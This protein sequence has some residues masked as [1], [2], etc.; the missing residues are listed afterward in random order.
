MRVK[1]SLIITI[2]FSLTILANNEVKNMIIPT[3]QIIKLTNGTIKLT[4]EISIVIKNKKLNFIANQI[5][6]S[7]KN[8][9]NINGKIS[10]TD[11]L[12]YLNIVESLANIEVDK[13]LYN[14]AYNLLITNNKIEINATTEKGLFY[15]AM[16]LIQLI[17]HNSTREIQTLEVYD[18]PNME[19]RGIS[20]DISR[21]QV[22]NLQNFKRIIY[23]ISRYKM[24]VFMPYLEDMLQLKSYP[25]I[26]KN[27]G[28]LSN[29]EVKE[30]VAYASERYVEVIP[31]FQTLGHFENILTSREF[32]DYAEFPGAASLAVTEAKT[33]VFLEN[34]LKE[35][36]ALFPSEY[37][38]IGADESYDVGYGKSKTLT[39]KVGSAKVHTEH[40]K[41]IFQ[42]CKANNKKVLMYGDVILNHTDILNL[43]PKDVIIVDWHYGATKKYISTDIFKNAGFEFIVSPSVWNFRTTF[44]TYQ[45][46]LPNIKTIIHDGLLNG[47]KGM[48]NSNWGDYG[49]ETFK[50]FVL[51]GYAW[52]AQCSWNYEDSNLSEFNNSFF[53]DF[54]GIDDYKL[55]SLYKTFST[56]FNQLQWHELWRHPVLEL[57]TSAWWAP[58]INPEEI[59]SWMNWTL[60]DVFKTLEN[61]EQ[62]VT[63]NKDHFELL[64]FLIHLDF[65]YS[66]KL[67]TN[68]YLRAILQLKKL[69]QELSNSKS[70]EKEINIEISSIKKRLSEVSIEEL[71]NQNISELQILKAKYEMLWLKYYKKENL[72]MIMD[73]FDRLITYFEE[74]KED[75]Q[76][77]IL[78]EPTIESKWIY[79]PKLRNKAYDKAEFKREF[80]INNQIENAQIQLIADTHAKL[81]INDKYVGEIYSRRSLSLLTEYDRILFL[82]A[83]K[84]FT[85]GKNK[86]TIEAESHK[87]TTGAGI[88]FIGQI[89]T[90]N[91]SFEVLSDEKWLSR[92]A[93]SKSNWEKSIIKEYKFKII[94][95]NFDRKRTSWIER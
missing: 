59:S 52:S 77:D 85:K 45:I 21:G 28:A 25:S 57:P 65:Y 12:I 71:I 89:V 11:G 41:K 20:D 54:F 94:A 67:E 82:D 83:K 80:T 17:E 44:P 72:N 64:R 9:F 62:L 3:P 2:L 10:N 16:S 53:A 35:V 60:P 26:G 61:F 68:Y 22:S 47:S 27:R 29:K 46:A 40:Y 14:Q 30:I 79:A 50:E 86:I 34:M 95:P 19:L 81:Y 18:W 5:V 15:G 66:K 55:N 13:N 24:N 6:E 37:I 1:L 76:S 33:Y 69:E 36:F 31:I 78:K 56:V 70:K 39:K 90:S 58:R 88:N 75:T 63:K 92:S 51:F 73:K 23:F 8:S 93:E 7:L 42:F 84:Y 38:N 43:I 49:A 32:V 91:G 4:E 74:T 48:I 87:G